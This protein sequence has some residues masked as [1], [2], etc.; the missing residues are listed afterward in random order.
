M[1]P[2]AAPRSSSEAMA[3]RKKK[4]D[5]RSGVNTAAIAAL[6]GTLDVRK[7]GKNRP[8]VERN[9]F[10]I[11]PVVGCLKCAEIGHGF[12]HRHWKRLPP[13]LRAKISE[14]W[15]ERGQLLAWRGDLSGGEMREAY[16]KL[17]RAQRDAVLSGVRYLAGL[18]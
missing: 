17:M 9:M 14:M 6:C 13:A 8:L 2:L 7:Q 15:I 16:S 18:Q 3:Q 11:C 1:S 10:R 4:P 12:C 5:L